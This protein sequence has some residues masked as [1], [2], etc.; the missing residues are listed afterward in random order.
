ML[1]LGAKLLRDAGGVAMKC[2]SSAIAHSRARWLELSGD[3]SAPLETQ[4]D[5]FNV[6]DAVIRA[7][8]QLP[9]SAGK[10]LYSC[11]AHLLGVPDVIV[12]N[13]V[14]PNPSVAVTL[15][16][17]FLLYLLAEC[18]GSG[19]LDYPCL[20]KFR[21]GNVFRTSPD[22]PRFKMMW[23]PCTGYDEDDFFFNSFG[24]WRA[25]LAG[26]AP[27]ES[28]AKA[29]TPTDPTSAPEKS[30]KSKKK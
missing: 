1:S 8:V 17:K 29:K 20:R 28:S 26:D 12:S 5:R 19:A 6:V 25:H 24:R 27:I 22:S 18:N 4:Q 15:F 2:E 13:A 10:D 30:K 16:T 7:F 3:A 9:I 11:G 14:C 23:E 21:Q